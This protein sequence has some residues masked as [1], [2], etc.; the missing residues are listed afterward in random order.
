MDISAVLTDKQLKVKSKVE[1][2]CKMLLD[3]R[4]SP[5]DLMKAARASKDSDKGT[6][7][8][9]I[10]FATKAKPELASLDCLKFVTETLL[11]EA[12]RVK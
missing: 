9:A 8:E 11:D 1:I 6:C 3:E 5:V 10:E 4:V 2:L 7:I 12:P